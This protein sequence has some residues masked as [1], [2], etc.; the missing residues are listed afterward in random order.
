MTN[1]QSS[2]RR[3][4]LAIFMLS[5]ITIGVLGIIA[6]GLLG[7]SRLEKRLAKLRAEGQPTSLAELEPIEIADDLNAAVMLERLKLQL[8]EFDQLNEKLFYDHNYERAQD[9][10]VEQ[11]ELIE[12]LLDRY[13]A[14]ISELRRIA[15]V[16]G[17]SS[18]LALH[19]DTNTFQIELISQST[20]IRAVARLI[21]LKI[22]ALIARGEIDKANDIGIDFLK[23]IRLY[24]KEPALTN[25][26]I[27]IACRGM[28]WHSLNEIVRIPTLSM[29]SRDRLDLELA[30]QT[31]LISFRDSLYSER[32]F[33]L[34]VMKEWQSGWQGKIFG[35]K[36]K[37][38]QL[39]T[40]DMYDEVL[41]I[42]SRPWCFGADQ[43]LAIIKNSKYPAV[44]QVIVTSIH[45]AYLATNRDIVSQ[46]SLRVLNQLGRYK[47]EM[48]ED[49]KSLSDLSLNGKQCLDPF[50]GKPLLLKL[51][52]KGWIVYSVFEN[53][54]DDG[55]QCDDG[56]LDW[57][58]AP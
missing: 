58:L 24:E 38:W 12:S 16:K 32:V 15:K 8:R 4:R 13:G 34:E 10:T 53:G 44:V 20:D 39:V 3:K 19:N 52:E 49:A 28:A 56:Q 2:G 46:R 45:S 26:L 42:V 55:G 37:S 29:E 9:L 51:T 25:H 57:G 1:Q 30:N 54:K 50:S 14:L 21:S 43:L 35:W 47:N 27:A 23:I 18:L 7:G 40:L 5:L 6:W 31:G 33:N 41:P 36:F 17:Y 11:L 48:G 22:D